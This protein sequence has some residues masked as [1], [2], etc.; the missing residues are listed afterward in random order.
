MSDPIP[1]RAAD[2]DRMP[3]WVPR[4]IALF[5]A[6]A[7]AL[8]VLAWIV[9]ELRGLLILILVS[10]FLSFALEPAV[11]R[12]ERMGFR[13][14]L[15]TLMVFASSA[16]ALTLFGWAIGTVVADQFGTFVDEAPGYIEEVQEWAS[17][18]V[19]LEFDTDALVSE[20]QAGGAATELA[21]RLAGDLVDLGTTALSLL[22]QIFTVGLFTFYLVADGPRLRRAILSVFAPD[23][24]ARVLAIWELAIDKTG[25]YLYS[26]G[27]LALASFIVHFIGFTL[28]GVPFP[29]ALALWVGVMS[30]FIPVIG[31]YLAG[32]LP[33]L[34]ALVNNP[35]DAVWVALVV[36][37]YQQVENY[38]LA[39]P[40]TAHT[41]DV[42]PAVAFG[43]VLAGA[44]LLGA[45]GAL[46]ALPAAAV[47]QA[48]ASTTLEERG[49]RH[50]V[51]E[52]AGNLTPRRFRRK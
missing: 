2:P 50:E 52:D 21:T 29:L 39:P 5:F 10:L 47:L 15:G 28:I 45:V 46:L 6:M 22:L 20:F 35:T 27:L 40:V 13:R 34:I 43:S 30:Q 31:T 19:G 32:A 8:Y 18:T 49:L 51:A 25:G 24:Q 44:G 11:N 48:F 33:I 38:I 4:A 42:H 37:A 14:S 3:R 16:V 9:R 26:R 23:R 12:L 17:D 41:M 36:L 1:E 7:V